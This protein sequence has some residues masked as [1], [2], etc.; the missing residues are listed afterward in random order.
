MNQ[1]PEDIRGELY[2]KCGSLARFAGMSVSPVDRELDPW[3]DFLEWDGKPKVIG[4]NDAYNGDSLG[5]LAGVLIDP[6]TAVL[7]DLANEK[8]I[9]TDASFN[10]A[11]VYDL[12]QTRDQ[13]R[14]V[15]IMTLYH[16][17]VCELLKRFNKTDSIDEKIEQ[18]AAG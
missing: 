14:D 6:E 10:I 17:L 3:P 11:F 16:K 7:I 4:V 15:E 1:T 5:K 9:E 18:R 13:K 8:I 12:E 2:E